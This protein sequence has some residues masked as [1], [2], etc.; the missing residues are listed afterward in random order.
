M[1][2]EVREWLIG[3]GAE[4]SRHR[5]DAPWLAQEG[6][7]EEE[8]EGSRE[9]GGQGGESNSQEPRDTEEGQWSPRSTPSQSAEA[10]ASSVMFEP[11]G[12]FC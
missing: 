11:A 3:H 6:G 7:E 1:P 2:N 9:E 8:E 4:A 12:P 5:I 10:S